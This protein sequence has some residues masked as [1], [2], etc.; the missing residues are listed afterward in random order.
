MATLINWLFYLCS[1]WKCLLLKQLEFHFRLQHTICYKISKW[2]H[3]QS[4]LEN[5]NS[6]TNDRTAFHLCSYSK[7]VSTIILNFTKIKFL[8]SYEDCFLFHINCSYGSCNIP[9]LGGEQ[10]VENEITMTS[11]NGL[12]KL[13]T[14]T[15]G[16]TQKAFWIK[17]SKI[18]RWWGDGTL[19]KKTSRHI[20]Q[21]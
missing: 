12:C 10:E 7:F 2:C 21:S 1:T 8:K 15:F 4:D 18:V 20:W 3:Y 6:T 16:K 5:P 14:V 9:F 17:R 13:T 11:W 19:K